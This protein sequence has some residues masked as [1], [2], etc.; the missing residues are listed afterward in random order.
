[1]KQIYAV[2]CT[3]LGFN[4]GIDGYAG[5]FDDKEEAEKLVSWIKE[6][7][8]SCDFDVYIETITL[9]KLDETFVSWVIS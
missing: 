2:R 5:Y 6:K 9:G 7:S 3:E 1:M 8:L 4:D